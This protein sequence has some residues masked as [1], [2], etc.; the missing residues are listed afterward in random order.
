MV[1]AF[2]EPSRPMTA[3]DWILLSFFLVQVLGVTVLQKFGLPIGEDVMEIA[4]FT[5]WIGIAML[6]LNGLIGLDPVRLLL[7][8]AFAITAVASQLLGGQ[9]FSLNSVFLA[10]ALYAPF[11]LR[12][13]VAPAFYRRCMDIFLNVMLIAGGLVVLQQLIQL[14]VGWQAWPD[15]DKLT[16]HQFLFSGYNYLQPISY[17]AKYYKPNA[18]VFLEVSF[19]SQ[20]TTIALMIEL[21]LYQRLL[22]M[23]FYAVVLLISFAGTGL[24]LL[25]ICAPL[26]LTKLSPRMLVTMG[27]LVGV[28]AVVAGAIGWYDQVSHRFGEIGTAGSSGYYRF[29]VPFQIVGDMASDPQFMFTGHGAGSTG[30]GQSQNVAGF[31]LVPFAK[32]IYEYGFL[33]FFVFYAFLI[34]SLFAEAPSFLIAFAL[35]AFFNMGGGGFV[36]PV[37]VITCQ[38]LGTMLRIEPSARPAPKGL[39]SPFRRGPDRRATGRLA[40]VEAPA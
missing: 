32:I 31:I 7:F 20:F 6:V 17:G 28:A 35:F 37:Y 40:D 15:L 30:S 25:A 19:V 18:F 23:A 3:K 12:F 24:L 16:P 39:R 22:R 11:A 33:T 4:V 38:V 13:Y 8:G 21:V 34:Y 9:P 29:N 27:I 1:R 14:A 5:S 36:V 26:V 2:A 10:L